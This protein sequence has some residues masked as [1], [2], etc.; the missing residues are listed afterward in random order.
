MAIEAHL[1]SLN[2]RH[3]QLEDAIDAELKR[4]Q[5]DDARVHEL[6]RLKLQIKDQ[7]VRLQQQTALQ[8]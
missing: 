5:I 4:P 1:N 6:K 2:Q 8:A 3:R 7:I